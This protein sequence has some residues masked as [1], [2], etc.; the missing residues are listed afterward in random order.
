MARKEEQELSRREIRRRRKK[1]A[2]IIAY[3]I[4]VL[5]A[6]LAGIGIFFGAKQLLKIS[7]DKKQEELESQQAEEE[8]QTEAQISEPTT[9]ESTEEAADELDVLVDS[10]IE[11]MSLEDKVAGLFIVSFHYSLPK[12]K[13]EYECSQM[14]S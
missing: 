10:N 14:T 12:T 6:L 11:T 7:N 8:T 9:E 4:L 1:R 2:Q 13:M 5:L 3:L